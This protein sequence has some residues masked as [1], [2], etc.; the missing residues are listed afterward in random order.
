MTG[1]PSIPVAITS[2]F[3][4]CLLTW[5]SPAVAQPEEAPSDD[6]QPSAPFAVTIESVEQFRQQVD[7]A[8]DIE[9]ELKKKILETCQDATD[10]ITTAVKFE[11]Q[12]PL[13]QNAIDSIADQ[14]AEIQDTLS[15]PAPEL[16]DD[17]DDDAS[18]ADLMSALATR[19]PTL[20]EARTKLEKLSAEPKRRSELRATI[21]RDLAGHANEKEGLEQELATPAPADESSLLTTSRKLLLQARIRRINAAAPAWQS[22]ISRY[23]AEKAADLVTLRIQLAKKKTSRLQQEVDELQKRITAKRSLDA[24][25]I[26]DELQL[27]ADGEAV[28]TPYNFSKPDLFEGKLTAEADLKTALKTSR[29]ADENIDATVEL[30]KATGQLKAAQTAL[31][32]HRDLE[33]K[34]ND[35]IQRVGLTGAIGLE[36]RR[37]LRSLADP[38]DVR[39]RCQVRQNRMREVEFT[40]LDLEDQ[41]RSQLRPSTLRDL[42]DEVPSLADRIEELE[43]DSGRVVAEDIELRLAKDRVKTIS[44][45]EKNY[46]ELFDRLGELDAIEQEYIREVEEFSN[47]IRQRV[48]WIRSHQ[49]PGSKDASDLLNM[50]RSTLAPSRW[51]TVGRTLWNDAGDNP[52]L[53]LLATFLI[54]VLI[55]VH[56][57][58]RRTL[59]AIGEVVSKG[60]CRE[61]LPTARAAVLTLVLSLM[62]PS[63]PMFFGWRLMP[64]S[65][66]SSFAQAVGTGLLA[67]TAALLTMDLLRQLC[68]PSGLGLAHFGWKPNGVQL[69]RQ[70]L[71]S[72]IIPLL[73]LL[74]LENML[75]ALEENQG[76]D[77]LERLVFVVGLLVL[78]HFQ[79]RVL[80]PRTGVFREFY[81]ASPKGQA[82]KI[83]WPLYWLSIAVPIT[84]AAMAVYGFYYTAFELSW[85]L[86][87]LTWILIGLFVVRSFLLRWFVVRHRE[88]KIQQARQRRQTLAESQASTG[89][90]SNIP[91]PAPADPPVDLQDVSDQTQRLIN[92][93]LAIV[94]L[95]I[96]WFVWVDVLPALGILDS[97]ELWPTMADVTV[98]DIDTISGLPQLRTESQLVSITVADGLIAVMIGLLTFTAARNIPGLMEITLLDRLP[99]DAAT[100]YAVRMVARYSIVVVG[101]VSA[102]AV[103]GIGWAKVQWLAAGLTVGL[104]FGLQEIFAN[105]VSGLIILFERPVRIGDVVTI[106]D[107]TGTV[108]RI[109]IRA[110]TITD[111]D[112][113]EYIVPNKEFVTGRLL[114]WTLS[115]QTNRIVIDVGVAY[116]SDTDTARRLLKEAAQEHPE[117]MED[118]GPVATFE[119]FGDSTLDLRLRCYIPNLDNRL[120]TI[121][122]LHEAIDQKFKTAKLEIPFP[123]RDLHIKTPNP[124]Q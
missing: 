7:A 84:L 98:E 64:I 28:S 30:S 50:T 99:L 39:Q 94:G 85:R 65:T 5:A 53:Y 110:T 103:I 63:I 34:V 100:R 114:N 44:A 121:T 56:Q 8:T 107:V 47:F 111:W 40:R 93:G 36:L 9:D 72:L 115:D 106:S 120:M 35:S 81:N 75:H 69:L 80:H 57:R 23:D 12:S 21:A 67:L 14:A 62:W 76:R 60:T 55:G 68:R 108:S 119:G 49:L 24:R 77:A 3:L 33:T 19:K 18:L 32:K 17:F 48:L 118:P 122:A 27:F 31:Q 88:L 42:E 95:A 16:L 54:L 89:G 52:L 109:H 79:F 78:A 71:L 25:Y 105:F 97:W 92:S 86:H 11:D 90:T 91:Q 101:V 2:L 4:L 123:Q 37:H 26:S 70:R 10:A 51:A 38:W 1:I 45:L 66:S 13:D 73:P 87:V 58:F 41:A 117:V 113:K 124:P 83:R 74:F 102:F 43:A 46:A 20:Q 59:S 116:G 15:T 61:F 96:A 82:F 104:G 6:L 29:L 112:R 22:A